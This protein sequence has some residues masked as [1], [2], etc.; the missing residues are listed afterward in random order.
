MHTRS[1]RIVLAT[2]M[3]VTATAMTYY[4]VASSNYSFHLPQFLSQESLKRSMQGSSGIA[5]DLNG[6]GNEDLVIGAPYS[7][8]RGIQG[9]LLIYLT[10][11]KGFRNG[12]PIL[13]QGE[14]NLG[15]SL[16]SLGDIYGNGGGYFAAGAFSGSGKDTSL[17]GTVT[18]FKG[19]AKI[20]KVA[21]IEGEN[22]LDKFGYALASGDLNGDAYPDLIVGAPMHSPGAA[23]Y[24]QGAVYIYF[25]PGYSPASAI[26]IPATATAMGI[27][28][29]I[30]AGDINGDGVDDL[31]MGASGKVLGY[32]GS[33]DSFSPSA[34]NPDVVF[35][36]SDSGFGRAIAVLWDLNGDGFRDVAVG[37]YTAVVSNDNETG[38]LYI[39]KGGNGPR[40][41]NISPVPPAPLPADVLNR[42]DGELNSGRFASKILPVKDVDGDG[43][44]E[45]A[46]T[47]EHGDG[48][49][50]PMTGKIFLFSGIDLNGEVSVASAKVIPGDV[51]D[52]HLGSFLAMIG[53]NWLAAG[54]PTENAGTGSVRLFDLNA[55]VQ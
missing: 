23:L 31:L 55:I 15:W 6:D 7:H 46:V 17:S 21:V 54:A 14:G 39:L 11:P 42:I 50:W 47:A 16:V 30:A 37:A 35:S 43:I 51:R 34:G 38:R 48:N 20:S 52:M 18:V 25:G 26:K 53:E 49:P 19:G 5:V 10:S 4:A 44:P 41:V 29:S 33:K 32:Y 12:R 27:G 22:A 40:T 24:Q 36:S 1:K 3:F 2:L 8:N 13:L 28:I 9:S 45:L